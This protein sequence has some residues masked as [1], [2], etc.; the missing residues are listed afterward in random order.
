MTKA[1]FLSE[2]AVLFALSLLLQ[3]CS[4][5]AR[6][7]IQGAEDSQ[8]APGAYSSLL[9][10]LGKD[11][12]ALL[13][14]SFR[15]SCKGYEYASDLP[16]NR[17]APDGSAASFQASLIGADPLGRSAY[18]LYRLQ[19]PLDQQPV[20][21]LDW[22]GGDAPQ[23]SAW[24]ALANWNSGRWDFQPLPAGALDLGAGAGDYLLGA[25]Q[26]C[27]AAVLF[28]GTQHGILQ[29]IY[30]P[31]FVEP[32]PSLSYP[33][34]DSGQQED[35]DAGG[36][37]ISPQAGDALYG[38]DGD[39]AG[40]Q[41]GFQDNGNG[42][43][44]DLVTGLMWQQDS[45]TPGK[46]GFEA[47][48]TYADA[49]TLGGYDDW[50]LPTIKELYSLIDFRG[51]TGTDETNATPYIDT[52]YFEFVY[53]DVDAGERHID[54]QYWSSTEYLSTTMQGDATVFGVNFADG[55][56]KGY[57]KQKPAQLGGGD[58]TEFVRCVRGNPDYGVNHFVDNGD[59]TITDTATGLTWLQQDSGALGAGDGGDG[60]LDWPQALAWAEGLSYAGHDDW[61]LPSAKELQSL[62][63]YSRCPDSSA[64][65]AIDPLF[66]CTGYTDG[67]GLSDYYAY[68]SSTTH[69]DGIN[70]G[71][72]ACYCCFGEALG[73]MD[74]P[75][76]SGQ[77]W[78][79]L[80]VHGA[81][82]QRSD[83]KTGDPGDYPHGHGPQGDVI[84]IYN[85][86][87]P[88]RGSGL[89]GLK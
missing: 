59:G 12:S 24:L 47:A 60:L 56:I 20:L 44:T 32:H 63:D 26:Q 71:D 65:P 38:Q 10:A 14:G 9:P 36:A 49:L 81:G 11:S 1:G 50:R 43:V 54:A 55:R 69:L 68:W 25:E 62:L 77:G 22:Q 80:D 2:L 51:V 64:S 83:P 39:Y 33:I 5:A 31:G 28:G 87:R 30:F 52:N 84:W 23:G 45:V 15:I 53:G 3:S 46:M 40:N 72:Y 27:L 17:C 41:P 61:R 88:V 66:N 70:P 78:Q 75:P 8:A 85:M 89:Q 67:N 48:K 79:L 74:Q 16:F 29:K 13:D 35:Y 58:F 73:W 34:V 7:A 4:G 57:P 21:S 19:L 82:A 42:T 76:G 6:G 37:V 18:A 86:V